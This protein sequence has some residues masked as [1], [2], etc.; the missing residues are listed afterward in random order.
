MKNR[1]KHYKT[2]RNWI[3]AELA[4]AYILSIYGVKIHSWIGKFIGG[5]LLMAPILLLFRLLAKD[6]HF[7]ERKR[8]FFNFIF[9]W[10]IVAFT[11]GVIFTF[12][13]T[14]FPGILA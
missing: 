8:F 6:E 4:V 11:L 10:L 5:L 13:E 1:E 12:I 7:S 3:I 9:G 14:Y 2:L